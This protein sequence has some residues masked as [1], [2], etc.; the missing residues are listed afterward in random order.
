[1]DRDVIKQ[2][3]EALAGSD[4]AEL[5]FRSNGETLRLVKRAAV[6]LEAAQPAPSQRSAGATLPA[7]APIP[8]PLVSIDSGPEMSGAIVA[9]VYGIVHLQETPGEPPLVSPGQSVTAGQVLCIIE[10]MKVFSHVRAEF[11]CV[12]AAVLV[13][14]GQEVEVGHKLFQLG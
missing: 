12:I 10:A 9:P 14:P 1:M 6:A 7:P 5:E 4:L 8:P 13:Q 3:I 2:L 11:D